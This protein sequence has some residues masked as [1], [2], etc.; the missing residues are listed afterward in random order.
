MIPEFPVHLTHHNA[1]RFSDDILT[2]QVR[3]HLKLKPLEVENKYSL[4]INY[5]INE[6]CPDIDPNYLTLVTSNC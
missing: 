5:Q 1:V 3:G 6:I 2:F 4:R